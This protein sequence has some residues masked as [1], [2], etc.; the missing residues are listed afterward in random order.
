MNGL[1]TSNLRRLVHCFR[2]CDVCVCPETEH[3]M[4]LALFSKIF[5]TR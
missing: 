1:T 4:T 3:M 5:K 2:W